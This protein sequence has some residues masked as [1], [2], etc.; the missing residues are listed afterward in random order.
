M[1][2]YGS[3]NENDAALYVQVPVLVFQCLSS[4]TGPA[5]VMQVVTK[6]RIDPIIATR[7]CC[8]RV[9]IL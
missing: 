7:L 3:L 2:H 4:D 9:F 1:E 8:L 6:R 5:S